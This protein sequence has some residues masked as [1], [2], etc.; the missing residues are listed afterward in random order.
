MTGHR[1]QNDQLGD[2]PERGLIA[3]RVP[4]PRM[5]G[6]VGGHNAFLKRMPVPS[7]CSDAFAGCRTRHNN[8]ALAGKVL[9]QA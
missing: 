5:R 3:G 1:G 9:H 2:G 4:H 6:R 7:G 8:A